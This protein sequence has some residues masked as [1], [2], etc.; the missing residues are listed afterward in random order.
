MI[1]SVLDDEPRIPSESLRRLFEPRSIALVGASDRNAWT[2]Q[3]LV[4][5]ESVGYD[6]ALHLVNPRSSEALGRPTVARIQDI[7]EAVDAVYIMVPGS[8]ALDVLD[9]AAA[10]GVTSGVLLSSGFAEAGP[11]GRARQDA[12]V[13]KAREHG[14]ALI[15]PNTLGFVNLA[16]KV[17]LFPGS[18]REGMRAGHVALVSQ[19]GALGGLMSGCMKAYGAGLS[20]LAST[21][22]EAVVSVADVVEY[23]VDQDTETR[24]IAV[25]AESIKRPGALLRAA[26]RARQAAKPIVML[27]VGRSEVTARTAAAHTG[28]IVGD[29]RVVD[30]VLRQAGIIRVD[31]IEA[32][33]CTA[34]LL[35]QTGRIRGPRLGVIGMSGGA[36]DLVADRAAEVGLELPE[37][38]AATCAALRETLADYATVQNPL[39]VTGAAVNDTEMFGKA[40]A[41][42]GSDANVDCLV[43][44]HEL[45]VPLSPQSEERLR[46][47]A[48]ALL[49]APAPAVFSTTIGHGF[50]EEQRDVLAGLDLPVVGGGVHNVVS[51]VAQGGWWTRWL[52]GQP[53]A[54]GVGAG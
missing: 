18:S 53:G 15:G 13:A 23:L 52:E 11:E 39:D 50:T 6:G 5:L 10:A 34:S 3:V 41:I 47:I 25:F 46:G 16:K 51:A 1:R 8:A 49:A 9:D 44:Q 54:L 14:M 19:S 42:V 31:S 38:S 30:A 4:A 32:L 45:A 22:N 26:Q 35:A 36:C 29:D 37:L 28:A 27:K 12:L 17:S 20:I 33:V 21:G 40:A 43:V 48:A 2:R 24:V 7:P